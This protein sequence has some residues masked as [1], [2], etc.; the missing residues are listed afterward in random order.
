MN[1]LKYIPY[2]PLPNS[3]E[4]PVNPS[5]P[6]YF[7]MLAKKQ[8]KSIKHIW[9]KDLISCHEVIYRGAF[10]FK[11]QIQAIDKVRIVVQP[12][13]GKREGIP[14]KIQSTLNKL[15][16]KL[17]IGKTVVTKL[18]DHIFLFEGDMTWFANSLT[19]SIWLSIIRNLIR[20]P[21]DKNWKASLL[22]HSY[23]K[24]LKTIEQLN[25]CFNLLPQLFKKKFKTWHGYNN[26]TQLSYSGIQIILRDRSNTDFY[27]SNSIHR[28]ILKNLWNKDVSKT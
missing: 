12:P 24:Q 19:F 18:N 16:K 22:Q 1:T 27:N 11:K 28:F 20:Y 21:E 2:K 25:R 4:Y 5:H 8:G 3:F 6:S 15:E 10:K 9:N 14:E 17:K 26:N 13:P 23:F 7:L